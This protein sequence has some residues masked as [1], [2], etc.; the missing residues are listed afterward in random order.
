MR[1]APLLLALCACKKVD[2]APADLD[3]L[4]H[5][6]LANF[7]VGEQEQLVEGL[8]NLDAAVGGDSLEE[9]TDGTLSDLTAEE[10]AH[11]GR[12]DADPT[13]AQGLVITRPLAC[14]MDQ[15][16]AILT[17]AAQDQLFEGTYDAYSRDYQSDSAAFVAGTDEFLYWDLSYSVS[18]SG[19]SY[20]EVA[21]GGLR[22]VF[23]DEENP[24]G[25][26]II[27]RT[28]MTEPATFKDGSN[29]SMGQDYQ[30][31]VYWSRASGDL[32]H[33]YGLWRQ[34]D[35]GSP[36]TTD[37]E[38]FQR[39]IVNGMASWDDDTEKLCEEGRP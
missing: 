39:I 1:A 26:A 3:G 27:A 34:A 38:S 30:I 23:A 8:V 21:L 29:K 22:N 36:F 37:N 33:V 35:Y 5:F 18:T 10:V 17:Y 28:V 25:E 6:M 20:D 15:L 24:M 2:P 9:T 13:L 12:E 14:T 19:V 31:E 11:L 7:D 4:V 32:I 16:R